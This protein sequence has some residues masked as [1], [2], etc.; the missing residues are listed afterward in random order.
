VGGRLRLPVAGIRWPKLTPEKIATIHLLA[1]QHA[2][3]S[4]R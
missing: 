1:A 2:A 4:A 3:R